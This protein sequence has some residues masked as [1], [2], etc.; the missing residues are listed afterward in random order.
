MYKY[1]LILGLVGLA[2]CSFDA[3]SSTEL[4]CAEEGLRAGGYVCVEGIWVPAEA[5]T[6]ANNV[7]PNSAPDENNGTPDPN[8]IGQGANSMV[9]ECV[10]ENDALFC[11]RVGAGCGSVTREDNCG[12]ERTTNCGNCAF[13]VVC[14]EQ[15]NTCGACEAEPDAEL[16]AKLGA[17]CGNPRAFDRCGQ[18]RDLDCGECAEGD[19]NELELVCEVCQPLDAAVVC[20]MQ[21]AQCGDIV[22]DDGCGVMRTFFCPDSCAGSPCQGNT[23][24]VCQPQSTG[25]FCAVQAQLDRCEQ[26]IAVDNCGETRT[27]EC[28]DT[29]GGAGVCVRGLCCNPES[30]QA[31]CIAAGIGCGAARFTDRCGQTRDV[32]CGGCQVGELCAAGQCCVP[33]TDTQLCA[34]VG[35]ECGVVELTDSCGQ[36]RSASCGSGCSTDEVCSAS[37]TCECS[38]VCPANYEC[39]Q[40]D[41]CG[42]ELSC[43]TCASNEICDGFV[44]QDFIVLSSPAMNPSRDD[45]FGR[46]VDIDGDTIVVGAPGRD[47]AYVYERDPTSQSWSLAATL[48]SPAGSGFGFFGRAVAVDESS[49]LIVIGAPLA[50][51]SVGLAYVF[52]NVQGSWVYKDTLVSPVGF[53]DREYFGVSVAVDG[54]T[55]AVGAFE[56][57][58]LGAPFNETPGGAVYVFEEL[59]GIFTGFNVTPEHEPGA[60][61]GMSVD[62]DGGLLV[63]GAPDYDGDGA[64]FVMQRQSSGLWDE[65]AGSP[66]ESSLTFDNDDFGYGAAISNGRVISGGPDYEPN[67]NVVDRGQATV[68][69]QVGVWTQSQPSGSNLGAKSFMGFDVDID[70]DV[71]VVGWPGREVFSSLVSGQLD[72]GAASGAKVYRLVNGQ[73]ELK[74]DWEPANSGSFYAGSGVA[75]SGDTIVV[76]APQR[77]GGG[78]QVYIFEVN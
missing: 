71:I 44:C 16:C 58:A 59:G 32:D 3:V 38:A 18:R 34:S 73:W 15:T 41:A 52:E 29:C 30:D 20:T 4:P 35:A 10:P 46:T 76:G 40:I 23:C 39:G 25:D 12:A 69:S 14:D 13:G 11:G 56:G 43:G 66:L 19:C 6:G 17:Q 51:M 21:G 1:W 42:Q 68:F 47:T 31:L 54:R 5:A 50:D 49:G 70:D 7:T 37:N 60:K 63:A 77:N 27:E 74:L 78:D 9:P 65:V 22:A 53:S 28:G 45:S 64:V 75:V 2:G 24:Q 57:Y 48:T 33:E 72:S 55:I 62:L 8:N 61:L 36:L 26:V 67:N